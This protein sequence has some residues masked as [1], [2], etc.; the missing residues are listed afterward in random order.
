MTTMHRV[1]LCLA[2]LSVPAAQGSSQ[3]ATSTESP[4]AGM[5][6]A[7]IGKSQNIPITYS[8]AQRFE[9]VIVFDRK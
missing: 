3:A 7:S 2:V 4:L 6:V 1:A 5:W 9:Q 8:R